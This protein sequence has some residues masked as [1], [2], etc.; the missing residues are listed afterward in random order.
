MKDRKVRMDEAKKRMKEE[1]EA[2]KTIQQQQQ[3]IDLELSKVINDA[4][5]IF[6]AAIFNFSLFLPII[7]TF[8]PAATKAAAI[9]NPIPELPPVT[10]ATFPVKSKFL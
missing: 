4:P 5:P 3:G 8:A 10:S 1:M 6:S 2:N 7:Q 9:A